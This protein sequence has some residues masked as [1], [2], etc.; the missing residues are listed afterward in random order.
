MGS[1]LGGH[2]L[3]SQHKIPIHSLLNLQFLKTFMLKPVPEFSVQFSLFVSPQ[4]L[5]SEHAH[6]IY[7]KKLMWQGSQKE[8]NTAYIIWA[9]L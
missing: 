6:S 9:P 1:W 4:T 3:P 5:P 8:T 2:A 7:F